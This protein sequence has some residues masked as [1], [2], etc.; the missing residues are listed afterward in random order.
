[1]RSCGIGGRY[2]RRSLRLITS[3]ETQNHSAVHTTG[4]DVIERECGDDKDRLVNPNKKHNCLRNIHCDG[5][6]AKIE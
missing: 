4:H 1:M 5:Y 2:E 6:T 3:G